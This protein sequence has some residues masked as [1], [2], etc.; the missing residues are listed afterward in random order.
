MVAQGDPNAA[1]RIFL[2]TLTAL[3]ECQYTNKLLPTLYQVAEAY[4]VLGEVEKSRE[5]SDTVSMMQEALDEVMK[6]KWKER[7]A[8]GKKASMLIEQVDCGN[9]F[10]KKAESYLIL[11][12]DS[13]DNGD[14]ECAIEL[15]ECAFRIQQYVLGPQHPAVIR[16]LRNI[17]AY[18]DGTNTG[19]SII[20]SRY[21]PVPIMFTS[22]I[23]SSCT[24]TSS[25]PPPFYASKTISF[26]LS[27]P[28]TPSP[29]PDDLPMSLHCTSDTLYSSS[30]NLDSSL[31][32][33]TNIKAIESVPLHSTMP[34]SPRP[35][36]VTT[37]HDSPVPPPL[38]E[39]TITTTQDVLKQSKSRS[40]DKDILECITNNDT[41]S[42]TFPLPYFN[43]SANMASFFALILLC[44]LTALA[45]ISFY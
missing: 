21:H 12:R 14:K 31:Q 11:V 43:G 16:S 32:D 33:S 28:S 38:E 24:Q 19:R 30:E 26:S 17:I 36:P 8:K 5:I 15:T 23:K 10:L 39:S 45:A 29:C 27:T 7:K 3:Q 37:M 1:L 4:S 41:R 22:V 44:S 25:S 2:E 40:S 20:H 35:P 42:Y 9:L 18:Y 13:Q 34:D 6:E